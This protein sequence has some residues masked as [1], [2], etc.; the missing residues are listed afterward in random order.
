M[1]APARSAAYDVVRRV[2]EEGAYAD[3]ALRGAVEKLDERDRA[4]AQRLVYGTVQRM[5]TARPRDRGDRPA[6]HPQ[7]RPARARG[8]AS[9]RVP[10]RLHRARAAR[11]RRRHGRARPTRRARARGAVHERGDAASDREAARTA[12][13][14]AGRT[15]QGVLPRLDLRRLAARPRRGCRAR[16]DAGAERAHGDGRPARARR[17]AGRADGHSGR[18]PGRPR[19][20]AGGRGGA[21]LAAEPRVAARG[22]RGRRPH[23]R[24][25]PRLVRRPGRQGHDARR[26]RDGSRA[27]PRQSARAARE[28][29]ADGR[30]E[31]ARG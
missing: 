27:Q 20:R 24:A 13:V 8:A 12:R 9:R 23:R 1:I 28:R 16:T 5:R 18:V 26:R 10:A 14:A 4:L 21:P 17:P 22:A 19:G 31:R 6:A 2:F 30:R 11:G 15:A 25:D 3:R 29:R 7:A